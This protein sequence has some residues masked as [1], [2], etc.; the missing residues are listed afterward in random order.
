MTRRNKISTGCHQFLKY[1]NLLFSFIVFLAG[2]GLLG[3]GIYILGSDYGAKQ[4]SE[5]LGTELYLIAAYAL[6]ATGGVLLVISMCGCCGVLRESRWLLGSFIFSL[7]VLVLVLVAAAIIVFVFRGKMEGDV[8]HSM[9]VVLIKKYGVDLVH[10]SDNRVITDF[11]N[12]LQ[13]ELKCCGVTGNINSTTSWAIY[14]HSAWYKGFE[15]GKPYVPQSCCNPDGDINICTG[16]TDY[17]GLPAHGPPF[18]ATMNTNPHLY[19]RGCYDELVQYVETHAVIIGVS[20]IAGVVVMLIG[21][22]FSV[23]LCRRIA[24]DTFYSAY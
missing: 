15:T 4:V 6:I 17:N 10:H 1:A 7:S 3:L 23:F 22:V 14:R 13:R 16:I 11:W 2:G 12:W 18:T 9:E 8:I 5:V 19:I 20:A 24:P 21:L